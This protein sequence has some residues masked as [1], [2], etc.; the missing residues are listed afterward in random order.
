V[1]RDVLAHLSASFRCITLD[2]PGTGLTANGT[3]GLREAADAVDGLVTT[4]DLHD[5]TLVVHDL[6]APLRW[7]PPL[8][9]PSA[10]AASP[11]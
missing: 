5:I 7:R 11:Q 2:A 8:D 3:V 9:G 1:W 10:S 6:A 4:L